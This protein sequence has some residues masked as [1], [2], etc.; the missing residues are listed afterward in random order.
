MAA[1]EPACLWL[2]TFMPGVATAVHKLTQSLLDAADVSC[3]SRK[4]EGE[5]SGDEEEEE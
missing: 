2:H 5:G 1:D 4:S 3:C